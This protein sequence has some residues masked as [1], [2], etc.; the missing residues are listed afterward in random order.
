[1]SG[2]SPRAVIFAGPSLPPADR[3]SDAALEWRPPVKQGEV[4][5]AALSQ[6][7]IIGII[8]GY[9]E[10]DADS[11]AQGNPVGDGAGHPC[12]RQRQHWR[13]ARR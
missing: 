10:V 2:A 5:K 4:Y 8:D 13:L 7:A 3:P 9:F 12:L 6:P 11:L 1:M